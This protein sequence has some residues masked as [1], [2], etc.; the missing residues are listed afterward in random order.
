[1]SIKNRVMG[2][3]GIHGFK[4]SE[5]DQ[6]S[7]YIEVEPETMAHAYVKGGVAEFKEL[8]PSL[9]SSSN[10]SRFEGFITFKDK[11]C[12]LEFERESWQIICRPEL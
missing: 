1:M 11:T 5:I 9:E 2:V 10:F 4:V 7:L 8:L 6:F 12:W 3:L